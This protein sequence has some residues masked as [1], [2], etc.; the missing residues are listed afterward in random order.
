MF[1]LEKLKVVSKDCLLPWPPVF[2][3]PFPPAFAAISFLAFS[4]G[5]PNVLARARN[6]RRCQ[7]KRTSLLLLEE[8][9]VVFV[10]LLGCLFGS[11]ERLGL[12]ACFLGVSKI[13][14]ES[15]AHC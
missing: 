7:V 5:S 12:S 6:S 14:Q 2:K 13:P 10:E 15:A 8:S 9:L 4:S 1:V 3:G 11:L